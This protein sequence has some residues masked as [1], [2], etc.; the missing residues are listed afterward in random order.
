[1]KNLQY[2]FFLYCCWRSCLNPP[3]SHAGDE[4]CCPL[5]LS[6]WPTSSSHPPALWSPV[7][8]PG[9]SWLSWPAWWVFSCPS[10]YLLLPS[11]PLSR[12]QQMPSECCKLFLIVSSECEDD[13]GHSCTRVKFIAEMNTGEFVC[14]L[15]VHTLDVHRC[16]LGC[17][18]GITISFV[19]LVLIWRW[20]RPH[21]LTRSFMT[22]PVFQFVL[23][24]K[25]SNN[26][27]VIQWTPGCD[28]DMY[29]RQKERALYT[30]GP[31]ASP[32]AVMDVLCWNWKG[33]KT[34]PCAGGRWL[35]G[36]SAAWSWCHL[37]LWLSPV[38]LSLFLTWSTVMERLRG[39]MLHSWYSLCSLVSTV[40]ISILLGRNITFPAMT[41][42]LYHFF[43]V[44][45]F[46][47]RVLCCSP[48]S[49]LL[50]P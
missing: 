31:L 24:W 19:L 21:Q 36:I 7:G 22:P 15:N 39:I 14:L 33:Q 25:M 43:F 3:Q 48:A 29:S 4:R 49:T 40:M 26:G 42:G 9:Q 46:S 5:Q 2:R 12:R 27:C 34:Q 50:F 11:T 37:V 20:L 1:M 6:A 18:S 45:C 28:S 38:F 30:I 8:S 10:L 17:L 16:Y 23:F 13:L 41:D 47:V 32:W 44:V 35:H